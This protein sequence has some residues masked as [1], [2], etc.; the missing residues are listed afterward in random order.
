MLNNGG[1]FIDFF[2]Y[3]NK[4]DRDCDAGLSMLL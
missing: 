1:Y 2:V 3:S 4:T